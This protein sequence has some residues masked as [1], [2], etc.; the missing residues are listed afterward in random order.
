[1][2]FLD[3]VDNRY[4]DKCVG[5]VSE[6]CLVLPFNVQSCVDSCELFQQENN[7]NVRRRSNKEQ[8]FF[9]RC[10]IMNAVA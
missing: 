1:M 4:K 3:N 7:V 2:R 5:E 10:N 8:K 6:G 9:F